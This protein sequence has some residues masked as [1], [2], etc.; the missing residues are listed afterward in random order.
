MR[1]YGGEPIHLGI[2]PDKLPAI[3]RA[4]RKAAK[5]D[6]LIT[7]G[8]ASVGD[9]DLVQAALEAEGIKLSFWKIA[10]RP[11]KP[12]MFAKKAKQRII[13]LP[14]NPVSALVCARIFLKP[15]IEAHLGQTTQEQFRKARLVLPLKANAER[16]DY[17]RAKLKPHEDG[18]FRVEPFS[19]Q[20]SSMQK[21]LAEANALILRRPH[22]LAAKA[23]DLV[24]VLLLDF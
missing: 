22:A 5:A 8:G 17:I 16:Q 2:V 10:M 13:G 11:G 21:L 7:T 1:H 15:L 24:E 12:L 20:D 23:G 4:I 3:R 19:T 9:H 18:S 6:V 14:G